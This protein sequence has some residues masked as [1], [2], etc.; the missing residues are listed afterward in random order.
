MNRKLLVLSTLLTLL[1][2]T[3]SAQRRTES[4]MK[5][6]YGE[7]A[8]DSI[9]ADLKAKHVHTIQKIMNDGSHITDVTLDTAG[10]VI[11]YRYEKGVLGDSMVYSKDG[12]VTRHYMVNDHVAGDFMA[13]EYDKHK[14]PTTYSISKTGKRTKVSYCR[15]AR[16]P[17]TGIVTTY[18]TDGDI[19]TTKTYRKNNT[20]YLLIQT[21]D[22]KG[23][24]YEYRIFYTVTDSTYWNKYKKQRV[25]ERGEIDYLK[26]MQD[27]VLKIMKQ[28]AIDKVQA[29]ELFIE[30]MM[31]LAYSKKLEAR[32]K[33]IITKH[34]PGLLNYEGKRVVHEAYEYDDQHNGRVAKYRGHSGTRIFEFTYNVEGRV[35][36]RILANV[37]DKSALLYNY[38]SNG[39][40]VSM[41]RQGEAKPEAEFKYTFYSK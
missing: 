27:T 20:E 4:I 9:R 36:K 28:M 23:I 39:L 6:L 11:Y 21:V 26:G 2:V 41:M 40:P 19:H 17:D 35:V 8:A 14:L 32:Q 18:N 1:C 34:F 31:I 12:E 3:A 10:R 33:A 24:E 30:D 5:D 22:K 16:T 13:Y 37:G 29:D 15:M 38:G 25:L 7:I